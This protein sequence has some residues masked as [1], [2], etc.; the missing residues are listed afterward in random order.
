V[1]REITRE[2][3]DAI[4]LGLEP[5]SRV[6]WCFEVHL[7]LELTNLVTGMEVDFVSY[8]YGSTPEHLVRQRERNVRAADRQCPG[9]EDG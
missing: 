3:P 5:H 2:A 8:A 1:Y 7:D 6:T 4:Q 9:V